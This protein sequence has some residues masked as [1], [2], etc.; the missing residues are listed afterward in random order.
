MPLLKVVERHVRSPFRSRS[1]RRLR[2]RSLWSEL[3]HCPLLTSLVASSNKITELPSPSALPGSVLLRELWLNGNGI[4]R[5][6]AL[7]WL[8]DLQRLYLQDNAIEGIGPLWGCLN[9]EVRF[10][11]FRS[12]L[13]YHRS[14]DRFSE[15]Y[16]CYWDRVSMVVRVSMVA[17]Q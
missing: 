5:L 14:L 10:F 3:R 15:L 9:L 1:V 2:G 16:L 17:E 4:R 8:P 12:R 7:S 11:S 6:D 13:L